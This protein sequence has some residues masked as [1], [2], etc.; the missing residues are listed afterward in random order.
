MK[1]RRKNRSEDDSMRD[2]KKTYR[3]PRLFE[4]G[5]LAKLTA[6]GAAASIEPAA[7]K[8]ADKNALKP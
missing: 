7:G 8:K 5:T 4:Y 3:S 2:A 1:P 6:G